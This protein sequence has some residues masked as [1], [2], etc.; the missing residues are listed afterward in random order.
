MSTTRVLSRLTDLFRVF[1]HRPFDTPP[2]DLA[3]SPLDRLDGLHGTLPAECSWCRM[4]ADGRHVPP[5]VHEFAQDPACEVYGPGVWNEA[6]VRAVLLGLPLP[7]E[8]TPV[9]RDTL[10]GRP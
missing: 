2:A 4:V 8:A 1:R 5:A 9:Y 7:G 6:D 10:R 3:V